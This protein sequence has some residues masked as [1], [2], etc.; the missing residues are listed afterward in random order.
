MI[1]NWHDP[2][3]LSPQQLD[4]YLANAWFRMG[5]SIFTCHFLCFNNLVYTALWI[6]LSLKKYVFKKRLRKILNRNRKGFHIQIQPAILNQQKNNLYQKYRKF[7]KGNISDCLK[8]YLLDNSEGNIY[9][10]YE[11]CV[12]DNEKLIA[13]SFFDVGKQSMASIMGV[14]D[15]DYAKYSLGVYT[16]LEEINFGLQK[17]K[18]F[19]YPGYVVPTYERFDYKLRI[20]DVDYYNVWKKNWLPYKDLKKDTLPSEVLQKHLNIIKI[21]LDLLQIPYE[22]MVYPAHTRPFSS[23]NTDILSTPSFIVLQEQ[24]FCLFLLVI[25]YNII[26]KT[27]LFYRLYKFGENYSIILESDTPSDIA[28]AIRQEVFLGS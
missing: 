27:Y 4:D 7:F 26:K 1:S 20:G 21:Y 14:Y 10:T 22:Q 12:Y 16:M 11:C 9:N 8:E 2:E 6:R 5:Q 3:Q 28:T 19:Y 18:A 24:S 13:F 23:E 25:E 15:P 17:G